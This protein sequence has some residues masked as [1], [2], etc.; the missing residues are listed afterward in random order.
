MPAK[1]VLSGVCDVIKRSDVFHI[2]PAEIKVVDGWN[3]RTDFSGEDD[4]TA[5]IKERGV[6]KPL[7]VKKNAAN[8]L[9]LVDGERR[10][11]ATLRARAEGAE[12]V[13]IPVQVEKRGTSDADLFI[14]AILSNGGKP[15]T[16]TE[17]ANAFKRLLNWG[18]EVKGIAKRTGRSESHVRNRLELSEASP[19]VKK[20]VDA[21]E[22]TIGQAMEITKE[23]GGSVERQG[24]GLSQAKEKPKVMQAVFSFRGEHVSQTGEQTP[25]PPIREL[26]EDEDFLQ[27]VTDS[28]F[29]PDSIKISLKPGKWAEA[30]D[31]QK[32][33]PGLGS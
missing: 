17:E 4:L 11:R 14:D 3:P 21:G 18:F 24:E 29:D 20:A 25:C 8:K 28:G 7:I 27:R 30:K 31:N 15:F 12:I 13:S 26:F 23:A 2:D 16:P 1:T 19:E 6:I 5:S 10:L 33:L 32:T 22:I 9:E